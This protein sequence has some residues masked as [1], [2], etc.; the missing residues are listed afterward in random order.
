MAKEVVECMFVATHL[1]EELELEE[2]GT[3]W[4]HML[5]MDIEDQKKHASAPTEHTKMQMMPDSKT[6]V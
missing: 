1:L 3:E 4:A 5:D 6:T 2:L